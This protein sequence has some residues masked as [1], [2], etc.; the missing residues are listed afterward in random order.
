[1]FDVSGEIQAAE[2]QAASHKQLQSEAGQLQR[3]MAVL[4]EIVQR[5]RDI[6]S[7]YTPSV[8]QPTLRNLMESNLIEDLSG[9]M[10][11]YLSRLVLLK[12]T[13]ADHDFN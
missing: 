6:I 4:G 13:K 7:R 5:Q 11:N 1:M 2:V 3:Q 9:N 10:I 12:E 8:D